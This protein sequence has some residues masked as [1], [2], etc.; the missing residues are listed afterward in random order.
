M[1]DRIDRIVY[2]K[3]K[4]HKLSKILDLSG[5]IAIAGGMALTMLLVWKEML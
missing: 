1:L 4:A 3:E 5:W 2:S